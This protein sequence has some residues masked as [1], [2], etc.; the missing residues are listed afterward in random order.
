MPVSVQVMYGDSCRYS[1]RAPD[2][3]GIL[4]PVQGLYSFRSSVLSWVAVQGS[5]KGSAYATFRK[6]DVSDFG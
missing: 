2:S 3:L 5:D 4:K 1:C 6:P